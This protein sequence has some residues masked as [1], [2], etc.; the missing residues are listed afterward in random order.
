M[1]KARKHTYRKL[2][3]IQFGF[4]HTLDDTSEVVDEETDSLGVDSG[5]DER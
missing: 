3:S 2:T 1:P 5:M 4:A